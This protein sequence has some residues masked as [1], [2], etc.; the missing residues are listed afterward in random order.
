[1][2][3]GTVICLVGSPL[4]GPSVWAPVSDR[5]SEG[6]RAARIVSTTRAATGDPQL[7]LDDLRSQI[8]HD[9]RTVIVAHSNAGAYLPAIAS[10]GNPAAL[11]F[12]DAILPAGSGYIRLAPPDFFAALVGLADPHGMLP[13]W[14]EWWDPAEVAELLPDSDVRA[15]IV[16]EQ[17]RVPLDYFR[18]SL[19]VPLGWDERPGAYISFGDTY[20][21]ERREASTRHW[22]TRVIDGGHLAMLVDPDGVSE[23]L[24]EVLGELG[25]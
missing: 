14:T 1:V 9:R 23:I 8:P 13:P 5:L 11:V 3:S 21:R 6:G 15:R 2:S 7:I 4:L 16:A 17:P 18:G 24:S 20:E 22:D 10:T 12:V 25:A 19:D